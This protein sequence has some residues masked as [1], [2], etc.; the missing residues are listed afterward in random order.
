MENVNNTDCLGFLPLFK[1]KHFL[2]QTFFTGIFVSPFFHLVP[3]RHCCNTNSKSIQQ[4]S[5]RKHTPS[6]ARLACPKFPTKS[7]GLSQMEPRITMTQY[8]AQTFQ[9]TEQLGG[10]AAKGFISRLV[11]W[12]LEGSE[13]SFSLLMDYRIYVKQ[14]GS[15]GPVLLKKC[16]LRKKLRK[17]N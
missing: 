2:N 11:V 14:D 7:C 16:L 13:T 1:M 4:G 5:R 6:A 12:W 3:I 8:T 17:H 9:G 15:G 10:V